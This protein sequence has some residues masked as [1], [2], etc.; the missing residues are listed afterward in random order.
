MRW[1]V[2]WPLSTGA[3]L[4]AAGIVSSQ[5]YPIKPVRIVTSDVGGGSDLAARIIAQA[6]S[7][8]LA[9]QAI[10]DNHGNAAAE[11]VARV[12]PDS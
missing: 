9:Q 11:V 10:V 12:A 7:G 5:N 3:L 1:F 8:S 6:L 2:A 4:L